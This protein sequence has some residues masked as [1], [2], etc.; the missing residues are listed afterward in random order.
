M[1]RTQCRHG[2]FFSLCTARPFMALLLWSNYRATTHSA[3]PP[4][5]CP[6]GTEK[7]AAPQAKRTGQ[8]LERAREH[9][10]LRQNQELRHLWFKSCSPDFNCPNEAENLNSLSR[11]ICCVDY[12]ALRWYCSETSLCHKAPQL[13]K[14]HWI[15]QN[16]RRANSTPTWNSAQI[17]TLSLK[18]SYTSKACTGWKDHKLLSVAQSKVSFLIGFLLIIYMSCQYMYTV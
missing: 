6:H 7:S 4:A 12:A 15:Y 13:M 11:N 9:S 10:L 3:W 14:T 16:I 18:K 2:Y 5:I 17:S 8:Q 1:Q